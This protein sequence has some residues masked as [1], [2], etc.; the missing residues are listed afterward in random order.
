MADVDADN[1]LATRVRA[2]RTNYLLDLLATLPQPK[3]GRIKLLDVG[4]TP[5]FWARNELNQ[6]RY[7]LTILNIHP[8]LSPLENITCVV[9]D[10]R[11]M[12]EYEDGNFA[13]VISDSV[14]EHVG[15]RENQMSMAKEV[16]RVGGALFLQTPNLWFPMETHFLMPWFQFYPT[17]LRVWILRHFGTG[18]YPKIPDKKKA[19]EAVERIKLLSKRRLRKYFPKASIERERIMG[20][21]NGF[22]VVKG[23]P[24]KSP[25]YR[26]SRRNRR[27][28]TNR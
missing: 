10:A 16:Q 1:S 9:G 2:K 26:T 8:Q 13:A 22:I 14:I 23:W 17:W 7:E 20:L 28:V 5:E 15:S 6:E 27:V 4:G 19:T 24:H 21:T 18:G 11:D 3:E 12:T 25:D